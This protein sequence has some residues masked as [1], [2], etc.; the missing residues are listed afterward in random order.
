MNDYIHNIYCIVYGPDPRYGPCPGDNTSTNSFSAPDAISATND[1]ADD[2]ASD[3][4]LVVD[5]DTSPMT[6]SAPATDNSGNTSGDGD[7]IAS[8]AALYPFAMV[9]FTSQEG[10]D[11]EF[12]GVEAKN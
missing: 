11:G 7:Y 9:D 6:G 12:V 1:G 8:F 4:P 2:A 10:H 5:D 3:E